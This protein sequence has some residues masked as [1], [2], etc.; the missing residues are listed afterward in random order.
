MTPVA[1]RP[2][3]LLAS[4]LLLCLP[5]LRPASLPAEEKLPEPAV[6]LGSP[7]PRRLTL[8]EARQIALSTS[9]GLAL[10]NLNIQSKEFATRAMRADYFPKALAHS[11]YFHFDNP[12]GTTFT[13]AGRVLSPVSIPVAVFN[14]DSSFTTFAAVQ[15]ITALLKVRQ[16]VI[17]A[18]AD[19]QIAHAQLDKGVREL[20]GG[21]EQLYWGLLATHRIRAGALEAVRGGEEAVALTKST[22]ARLALLEAKQA[23]QAVDGQIA[24]LEAQLNSL[25]DWPACTKL[26]VVEPPL[27]M[28]P[29]KCADDAVALALAASPDIREAEQNVVKARAGVAVAKV[30]YLPNIAVIGGY[31]KQTLMPSVQ[32]DINYVGVVGSYTFWEWGKKKA[33]VRQSEKVVALAETK[34]EMTRDDVRDK[35]LKAFRAVEQA[36]TVLQQAQEMVPLRQEAVKT[37]AG[38]PAKLDAAK[39]LLEA[40]VALVKADLTYRVAIVELTGLLG[41][42]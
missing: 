36:R 31:A 30:D 34:L 6:V 23:V 42:P 32:E 4:V 35:T 40:E 3:V 22:D 8:E 41:K 27:P 1:A 9:K 20:V 5:L 14:Q 24:D 7:A 11:D 28:V 21:V 13:T 12:L 10:A 16:G 29:V 18:R 15:P 26:D 17:V 19:E 2:R 38:L 37:A 25:L 39:N 33:V